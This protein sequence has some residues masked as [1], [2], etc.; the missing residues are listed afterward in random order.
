MN[1]YR[2]VISRFALVYTAE[3]APSPLLVIALHAYHECLLHLSVT[4][5]SGR[6]NTDQ[7]YETVSGVYFW[8][9]ITGEKLLHKETHGRH[10]PELTSTLRGMEYKK[11]YSQQ[12]LGSNLLRNQPTHIIIQSAF[13][14]NTDITQVHYSLSH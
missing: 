14:V 13:T 5:S 9:A 12:R 8:M 2:F 4:K 11:V 1:H 3:V 6:E 10:C 7:C